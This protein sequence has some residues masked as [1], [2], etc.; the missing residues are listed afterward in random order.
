VTFADVVPV[1]SRAGT[2]SLRLATPDDNAA[3]CALL[4]RVAMESDIGL[5]VRRDPD[6]DALYRLQSSTWE[7]YVVETNGAVEGIGTVLIRDGYLGG[8]RRRVGYLGDLRFSPSI[9]GRALLDRFYGPLLERMRDRYGCEHFL[10]AVIASNERALRALTQVTTRS[11]RAGRPRYT[12]VGDFDIRS[13]QLLLP[14]RQPRG[15]FVVRRATLSDLGAVATLLDE[16][17]RARPF[18]YPFSEAELR[19]RLDEWPGLTI[20]SFYLA[21]TR[22]GELV[23]CM[24][25]WD[26][27]EVKRMVVTAY[28]RTMRRARVLY[29]ALA[30]LTRMRPLP[31]VG[32]PFRYLYVTHQ[33]VPSGDA[34]I[35][36]ALLTTAYT[37]TRAARDHHFISAC[38][39]V[40]STLETAYHG[41][42]VTNLRARLFV[43][44]LPDIQV[45]DALTGAWPGFEMALV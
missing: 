30:W 7:S 38:A 15:E 19:R 43:V 29:D 4:A 25:L 28:R 1:T 16:D 9:E 35:L 20:D 40:G 22:R 44:T 2:A 45:P 17:A 21:F 11:Q 33:A 13:I 31:D 24:A 3:R 27:S 8:E 26:A 41:F 12:T 42:Q 18:G 14:R 37:D 32:A 39:P 10:T 6:F 34:R 5:S 36:R 23:G